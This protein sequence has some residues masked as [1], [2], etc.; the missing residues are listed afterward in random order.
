MANYPTSLP[1]ATPADHAVVL[2]EL[3]AIAIE[4][5][6]DPSGSSAD[7]KARLD[8]MPGVTETVN[9]V[10]AAGTT[11]TLPVPA[12]AQ[13]HDLTLNSASCA[14][15][16]PTGFTGATAIALILRQDATGGRAVTFVGTVTWLGSGTVP[17]LKTTPGGVTIL[18]FFTVNGGTAWFGS[19]TVEVVPAVHHATHEPAGTDALDY[20]TV[21][22]RGV[23]ASRPAA[24]STL[25]GIEYY[26]TDDRGGTRYRCNGTTWDQ[27][28]VSVRSPLAPSGLTYTTYPR[29][30][31]S[32]ASQTVLASGQ[33]LLAAIDLPLGVLVTNITF[34][35][36][37]A[38]A[39]GS[40]QWFSLRD[41]SR[42]LLG[43]TADGT[44]GAWLANAAKALALASPF[45]TTYAGLHYLGI[46][47]VATTLPALICVSST[48]T[49]TG[50]APIILGTAD[51]GLTTPATAPA[52][53][54]AL[55]ASGKYPYAGVS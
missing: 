35:S 36:G 46:M 28:G 42:N 16:L 14:I 29:A 41:S 55:T 50:I 20:T 9:T 1:S 44:S 11:E 39:T 30:G 7:V 22:R 48:G 19:G 3:R 13:N 45:T 38:L 26:A 18:T 27:Q 2:G 6:L 23:L 53:S 32:A 24:A 33:E 51:S 4:L 8:A 15:T 12:T 37:T 43:V 25:A 5:G 17:A 31:A 21:L 52:T 54:A 49:V 10:A 47:V 40:N 34:Y